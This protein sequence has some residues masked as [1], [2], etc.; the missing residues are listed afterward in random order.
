MIQ[1]RG[2]CIYLAVGLM[3]AAPFGALAQDQSH[4]SDDRAAS[5]VDNQSIAN[6]PGGVTV[7]H[8]HQAHSDVRI[9][10]HYARLD[11]ENADDA[12][13][14]GDRQAACHWAR[15]ARSDAGLHRANYQYKV[16][17]YCG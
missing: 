11:D 12:S 9:A 6:T 7:S 8:V 10:D 3:A 14:R 5:G 4:P 2:V 13:K 16:D 17:E 15:R 1:L